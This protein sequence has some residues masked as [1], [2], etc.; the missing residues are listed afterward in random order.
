MSVLRHCPV[1][2]LRARRL[3]AD[4]TA[5][6]HDVLPGFFRRVKE[7][8]TRKRP[9]RQESGPTLSRAPSCYVGFDPTADALHVGN[10]ASLRVL[11]VLQHHG[12]RPIALRVNNMAPSTSSAGTTNPLRLHVVERRRGPVKVGPERVNKLVK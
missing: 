4:T 2:A 10:L 1:R 12:L 5:S 8:Q 9:R 7:G 11:Q 3:I 6:E